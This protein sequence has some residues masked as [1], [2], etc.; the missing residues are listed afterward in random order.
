MT[1]GTVRLPMKIQKA[2]TIDSVPKNSERALLQF[3]SLYFI[4]YP[5]R[6]G[7]VTMQASLNNYVQDE[8][9]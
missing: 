5:W 2:K 6:W 7:A 3:N 4:C 1:N 9:S 8:S